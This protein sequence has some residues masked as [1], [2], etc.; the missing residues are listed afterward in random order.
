MDGSRVSLKFELGSI[1][2]S[3]G[4]L[5]LSL[6]VSAAGDGDMHLYL[7]EDSKRV[8]HIIHLDLKDYNKLRRIIRETDELL[9]KAL[10]ERSA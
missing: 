8:G 9:K 6:Q 4:F 10:C 7:C 2:N 1:S 3:S 5:G